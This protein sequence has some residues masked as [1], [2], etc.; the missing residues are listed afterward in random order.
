MNH[1]IIA[2]RTE[3]GGSTIKEWHM[4]RSGEGKPMCGRSIDLSE[5]E[6][7]A[8]AWGTERAMPFCH[9]CGALYLREVP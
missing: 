2:E 6:L 1:R 7:P 5:T 4:V 8:D 9:T 3:P